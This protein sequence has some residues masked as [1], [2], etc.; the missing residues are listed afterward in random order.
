MYGLSKSKRKQFRAQLHTQCQNIDPSYL[1][2]STIQDVSKS[3][4][5]LYKMFI[6]HIKITIVL[7]NLIILS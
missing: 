6:L 3:N 1:V 2:D 4:I 7:I 5:F